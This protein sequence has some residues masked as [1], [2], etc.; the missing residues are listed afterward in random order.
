MIKR[1]EPPAGI[2]PAVAFFAALSS[3]VDLARL[4]P[5]PF[6]RYRSRP[7]A[8]YA[9]VVIVVM[10]ALAAATGRL[11]PAGLLWNP[12]LML[13]W[14]AAGAWLLVNLAW[15][16]YGLRLEY[17]EILLLLA[18][19]SIM[20]WATVV[21]YVPVLGSLLSNGGKIWGVVTLVAALEKLHGLNR[22]QALVTV[23]LAVVMMT[24]LS[25]L[26]VP[27]ILRLF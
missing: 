11:E 14:V 7:E 23:V 2:G 19:V 15:R 24:I 10:G 9:A 27:N 17:R 8:I 5:Q 21:Q 13:A 1:C 18:F 22:R 12:P 26:M 3:A 6:C 4:N 25:R 16:I 20:G